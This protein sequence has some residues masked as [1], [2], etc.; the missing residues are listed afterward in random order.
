MA[1]VNE[2]ISA[3]DFKK[4][5]FELL[6]KRPKETSGIG[7]AFL[8]LAT[9]STAAQAS[10]ASAE[11]RPD[12]ALHLIEDFAAEQAGSTAAQALAGVIATAGLLLAGVAL[13]SPLGIATIMIASVAGGFFGG[14]WGK[15]L[16]YLFQDRSEE[17][18]RDTA[19][20]M[21]KLIFGDDVNLS[22]TVPEELASKSLILDATFS[23]EEMVA[24]AQS[25]IAWR[26][27]LRELN[28]FVIGDNALYGK[29]NTDGSLDLYDE[30]TD[31]GTMTEL[32][33]QDRAAM[34]TWK[35][36]Y[37]K[38]KKSYTSGYSTSEIEGNWCCEFLICPVL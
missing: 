23:R 12:E 10:Q 36:R 34:L 3:E 33:L 16:V 21:L 18:K 4:Y 37:D 29:H 28:T 19:K 6:N 32:Y 1:F 2:Y 9:T 27:A 22:S 13:T 11:G 31:L 30:A 8:L 15:E 17:Q 20:R 35:L 38:D 24:A 14:D 25:D 26:Y 5:N 7:T